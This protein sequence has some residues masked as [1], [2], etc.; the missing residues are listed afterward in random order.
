MR[1][2]S[3][4]P[5]FLLEL[6]GHNQLERSGCRQTLSKHTQAGYENIFPVSR[7]LYRM[8]LLDLPSNQDGILKP[9]PDTC[10]HCHPF[11]FAQSDL[12]ASAWH[13]SWTGIKEVEGKFPFQ[14]LV[15]LSVKTGRV[16]HGHTPSWDKGTN[17]GRVYNLINLAA[18]NWCTVHVLSASDHAIRLEA[19]A[20]KGGGHRY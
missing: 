19:I 8:D 20:K 2:R 11:S 14:V 9:H 15:C 3:A 4:W 13:G 1:S 17:Q 10:W 16:G 18:Q 5:A 7:T 12:S 6:T